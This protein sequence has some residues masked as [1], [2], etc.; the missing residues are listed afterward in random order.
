M[1]YSV[2]KHSF[3]RFIK[4][5][6]KNGVI[7]AKIS[8]RD[9][10]LSFGVRYTQDELQIYGLLK[11]AKNDLKTGTPNRRLRKNIKQLTIAFDEIRNM[12]IKKNIRFDVN[13]EE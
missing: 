9:G 4:I 2:F 5:T 3:F 1:S 7:R 6:S 8:E 11:V 12:N 13:I 10:I